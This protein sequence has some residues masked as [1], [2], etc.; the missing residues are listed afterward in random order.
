ME[1]NMSK[2]NETICW[3]CKR[4]TNPSGCT[5]SW[6]L[7]GVPVDNWEA[8]QGDVFR[9]PVEGT[10]KYTTVQSYIVQKCP[11][12]IRDSKY[13]TVEELIDTLASY[14]QCHRHS[15]YHLLQNRIQRYEE[16]T[17][18]T[19]P[20]WIKYY[21]RDRANRLKEKSV[22]NKEDKNVIR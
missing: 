11:L 3:S 7:D 16:E 6:A 21:F 22:H 8:I 2:Q 5:C 1:I 19:I 14:F 12:Y 18:E 10:D 15:V 9:I 4:A 17:G 20:T 13:L